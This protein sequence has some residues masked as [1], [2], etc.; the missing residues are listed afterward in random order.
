MTANKFRHLALELPGVSE[1]EHMDH[2]DFR[3]AGKIIATLGYP[4]ESWG[5]VKLTPEQQRSFVTEAPDAFRP[6]NGSWGVRGATNA[7]LASARVTIV[8]AALDTAWRNVV[9]KNKV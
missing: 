2:P 9:T 1:R 8:R 7:R 5:M 4:D 6:C 3:V